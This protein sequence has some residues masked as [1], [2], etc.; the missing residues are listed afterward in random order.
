VT[1]FFKHRM[2]LPF[3]G[4]YTDL[5]EVIQHEMVHQFQYD[6]YSGG[7]IGAGVQTIMNVNPPGWFMEGMAA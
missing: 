3:T 4:S 2:V 5:D 6:V 1:E 7:R